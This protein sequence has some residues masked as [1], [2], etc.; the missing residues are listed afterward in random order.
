MQPRVG[1]SFSFLKNITPLHLLS[2]RNYI[3]VSIIVNLF[4]IHLECLSGTYGYT[5]Q[6]CVAIV[7]I[8]PTVQTLMEAVKQVVVLAIMDFSAK[9]VKN[10]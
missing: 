9:K 3:R 2:N 10:N 5:V 8:C 7:L 1:M 6:G 4:S